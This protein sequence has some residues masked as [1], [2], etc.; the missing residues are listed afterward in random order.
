[1]AGGALE[2]FLGVAVLGLAGLLAL[3]AVMSHRR[4]GGQRLAIFAAA[5]ALFAVKGVLYVANQFQ[6]FE[7]FPAWG[8]AFDFAALLLLYF[9]TLR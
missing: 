9:G 6:S 2:G 4:V 5:F 7:P 1:M 8:P 3:V